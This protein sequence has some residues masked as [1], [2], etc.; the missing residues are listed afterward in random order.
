M[1]EDLNVAVAVQNYSDLNSFYPSYTYTLHQQGIESNISC[2]RDSR[3]PVQVY[4][5]DQSAVGTVQF[6]GTCDRQADVL[7]DAKTFTPIIA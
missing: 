2:S 5:S 1:L 3:S 6:N 4:P 7:P